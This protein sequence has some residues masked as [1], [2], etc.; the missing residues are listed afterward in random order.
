MKKTLALI[1]AAL[2]SLGP[3]ILRL[4]ESAPAAASETA[5]HLSLFWLV[6]MC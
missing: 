2:F 5:P 6:C 1:L 4:M 3:V